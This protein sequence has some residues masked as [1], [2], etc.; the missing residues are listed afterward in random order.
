M[1][2]SYYKILNLLLIL[3]LLNSC[4]SNQPQAKAHHT[5]NGFKNT[6]PEFVEHGL[7]SLIQWMSTRWKVEHSID[8]TDYPEFP[9][10]NNDGKLL[11]ENKSKLSV[12]WIGHA[13]TLIQVEGVSI[14]TDPIWS[15]RCSPV[16]FAGPKRYT[17]PGIQLDNLPN[18]DVV[19][20]SHNHYDHMDLPTLLELE[21]KFHPTFI[22]GLGNREF[23]LKEGLGSVIE[24]DWWEN[25]KIK[26]VSISFTPAQHFTGRGIFDRFKSLWGSYVIEGRSEKVYFAGDTGYS[27]HFKEIAE[28]YGKMDIAILP[29]GAFEPRWFMADV[30]VDPEQAVQAFED[31]DAKYFIPMHYMTFVLSDEKLDSP[32]PLTVQAFQARKMEL[33]RLI[34]FKIG[35]SRFF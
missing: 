22:A 4:I 29:I 34:A 26:D 11:R 18:I 23:L 20:I 14:L 21:K 33:S 35:E 2:Y 7:G 25:T 15:D 3:I 27:P 5:N 10:L 6:N 30:H 8:P 13:T 31:L 9:V 24:L 16:S 17:P 19:I 32:I 1:K 12:T 28:K